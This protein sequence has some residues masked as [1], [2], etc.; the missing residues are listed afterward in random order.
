VTGGLEL[1]LEH[2]LLTTL[3]SPTSP[4]TERWSCQAAARHLT[5]SVWSRASGR[6]D[7]CE[8]SLPFH[9]VL[10]NRARWWWRRDATSTSTSS[11]TGESA[12][13]RSPQPAACPH[14][15][16]HDVLA[17]WS[18]RQKPRRPAG[19]LEVGADVDTEP[20]P[21][22][23]ILTPAG[24]GARPRSR[25][26]SSSSTTADRG[27]VG[28][29]REAHRICGARRAQPSEGLSVPPC[30]SG[31]PTRGERPPLSGARRGGQPS[32]HR[33]RHRGRT[34]RAPGEAVWWSRAAGNA[35]PSASC[36]RATESRPAYSVWP[37]EV[38]DEAA[39]A[40]RH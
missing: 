3:S 26:T 14:R 30:S 36:W 27:A 1:L 4:S 29:R 13:W 8:G 32:R 19:C 31:L 12:T 17:H 18:P 24:G 23:C 10:D 2:R 7:A 25:V 37:S 9:Y 20:G 40:L 21:S 35:S 6:P 11:D 15:R 5:A 38:W 34:A 16:I 33:C 22:G 39:P 28:A